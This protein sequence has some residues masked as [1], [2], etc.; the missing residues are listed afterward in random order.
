[1][2]IWPVY[3]SIQSIDAKKVD[4]VVE[5]IKKLGGDAIGV[6]GDVAADD[7]PKKIVDATVQYVLPLT[8]IQNDYMNLYRKYGKINHI[9][10]NG[11]HLLPVVFYP[12]VS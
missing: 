9:V 5:E 4:I 6:A 10:N 3:N 7:F 2:L 8:L 11:G 12:I 1:M